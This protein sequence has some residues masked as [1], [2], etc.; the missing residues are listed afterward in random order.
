MLKSILDTDILSEFLKGHNPNV[1]THAARYAK[2]HG[3]FTF[4]SISVYEIA[5]GLELKGAYGQLKKALA[6]LSKNEEVT[7]TPADYLS[8]AAIKAK[9]RRIG[10]ALELP[11]CLIA[12]IAVRLNQPLVTGNTADFEAIQK[13]GTNLVLENWRNP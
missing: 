2:E 1:V 4:T 7:P 13:L 6:W 9:A 10:V 11:D 5:Y 3:I 8:A 12:A